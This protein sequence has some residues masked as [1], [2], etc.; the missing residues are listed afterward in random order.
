V[1][2]FDN[3]KDA[4][5][6]LSDPGGYPFIVLS[7]INISGINGFQLRDKILEDEELT[8]KCVPYLFLTTWGW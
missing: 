5:S 6:F 3:A 1:H 8:N 7:D 2:Y 4:L